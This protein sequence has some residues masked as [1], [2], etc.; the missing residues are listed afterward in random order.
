MLLH[1]AAHD[2]QPEAGALADAFGGKKRVINLFTDF[3]WNAG[4][5]VANLYQ[6]SFGIERRTHAQPPYRIR[7]VSAHGIESVI[8]QVGPS[9]VQ[10]AS[11]GAIARQGPVVLALHGHSA[12]FDFLT[13]HGPGAVQARV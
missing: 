7:A 9:L 11:P 8:D 5:G 6:H 1:H 10:L 13:E 3:L 12:L 4:T 2:I